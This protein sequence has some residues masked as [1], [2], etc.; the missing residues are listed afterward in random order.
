MKIVI[1]MLAVLMTA[2][3][4]QKKMHESRSDSVKIVHE[5]EYIEKLRD[6]VVYLTLKAES[7]E[8]TVTQDSST[9]ETSAALSHARINSDGT[10]FHSLENKP[11]EQL[12]RV[13]IKETSVSKTD[14]SEKVKI[15]REEIAIRMPLRFHEKALIGCGIAGICFAAVWL[16]ARII[17]RRT[18]K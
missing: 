16:T 15:E 3:C 14:G 5:V 6:T 1:I 7:R 12:V 8:T 4:P 11:Y 17:V 10:L 9:L 18:R 13:N 2:C